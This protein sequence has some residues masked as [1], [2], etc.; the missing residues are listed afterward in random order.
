MQITTVTQK[1]QVTIPSDIRELLGIEPRGKVGFVVDGKSVKLMPTQSVVVQT[2]G[3]FKSRR[4]SLT[5]K[6]LRHAA[7]QAISQSVVERM[8]N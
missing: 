6:E 5:A 3:A 7:E 1:G 2:A 8:N 4:P